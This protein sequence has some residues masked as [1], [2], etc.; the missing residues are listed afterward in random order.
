M[1]TRMTAILGALIVAA[2]SIAAPPLISLGH[3]A[4]LS[5]H[6]DS[7]NTCF[8]RVDTAP[9]SNLSKRPLGAIAPGANLTAGANG[10]RSGACA[11]SHPDVLSL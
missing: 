2:G 6:G 1:G 4:W 7:G 9:A 3:A 11:P 10:W 8:E 5:A